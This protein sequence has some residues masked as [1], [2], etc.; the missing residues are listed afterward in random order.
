LCW[1]ILQ[2]VWFSFPKINFTFMNDQYNVQV[3]TYE[4][5]AFRL[6]F[7]SYVGCFIATIKSMT[8]FKSYAIRCL[9]FVKISTN[10]SY[11]LFDDKNYWIN[12]LFVDEMF[13]TRHK[14]GTLVSIDFLFVSSVY[15]S[16]KFMDWNSRKLRLKSIFCSFHSNIH[17]FH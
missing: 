11:N 16:K 1:A 3:K 5:W 4:F 12:H 13:K 15:C 9:N 17:L 8:A 14:N 10:Q 7:D 2:D 6:R